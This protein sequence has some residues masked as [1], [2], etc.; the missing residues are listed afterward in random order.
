MTG[1]AEW[2]IRAFADAPD[3]EG[4]SGDDVYDVF[5]K[6]EATGMNGTKYKDW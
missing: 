3:S 2:G 4:G 6:S 1:N 5:S